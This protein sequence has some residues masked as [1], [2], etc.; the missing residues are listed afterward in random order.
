VEYKEVADSLIQK[1][2]TRD[3]IEIAR[4]LGIRVFY[5]HY[6]TIRGYYDCKRKIKMIHINAELDDTQQKIVCAHE[7]GH[8]ILHPNENTPFL[9]AHTLFSVRKLELEANKLASH[10][11][12]SDEELREYQNWTIQQISAKLGISEKLAEYRM[13]F[14]IP[15]LY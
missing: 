10:I 4:Q 15:R 2:H 7:V 5:G 6:G 1:Y 12:W 8:A 3:P 9:Q 14:I 13:Q 11:L